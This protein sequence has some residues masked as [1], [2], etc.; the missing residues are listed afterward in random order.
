MIRVRVR[1]FGPAADDAGLDTETVELTGAPDVSS[2]L[3]RLV[4]LHG[5]LE[6]RKSVLRFAVNR[7]Y[8]GV[9]GSL[10]DGDEVAVIP[11]VAGGAPDPPVRIVRDEI[12]AAGLAGSA[13]SGSDGAVCAFEGVVRAERGERELEALEYTAYDE[14]ALEEMKKLRAEALERFDVSEV[15]VV[16][17]LGR[18]AVGEAS[19]AIVVASPHRADGFGAC[20]FVIDELKE[21]IP[22]WKK[23]IWKDG[24]TTWVDPSEKE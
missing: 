12:D 21:R 18:L 4:E 10:A 5:A 17:R 19:V 9:E 22:I 6:K 14:M 11:P 1:Y 15:I 13:V 7:E 23:E 8:V 2:L 3:D 16:H 20:R 24:T